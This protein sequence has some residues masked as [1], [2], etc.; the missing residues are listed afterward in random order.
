MPMCPSP[1]SRP[2]LALPLPFIP[3][4]ALATIVSRF[5]MSSLSSG[6]VC[7]SSQKA[8]SHVM[9]FVLDTILHHMGREGQF[10]T[11]THGVRGAIHDMQDVWNSCPVWCAFLQ[12]HVRPQR[13]TQGLEI[14]HMAGRCARRGYATFTIA[15]A[16]LWPAS[17]Q[18]LL[19]SR[20]W[21]QAGAW[22]AA[23]PIEPATTLLPTDMQLALRRH[24]RQPLLLCRSTCGPMRGC[25]GAIGRYGD[26]AFTCPCMFCSPGGRRSWSMPC[27]LPAKHWERTA[28]LSPSNGS[29]T[30]QPQTFERKTAVGLTSSSTEPRRMAAHCVAMPP[31][32][33]N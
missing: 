13:M 29:P 23:I 6:L 24:L 33:L 18:A 8:H 10:P 4:L 2:A 17:S 22:L 12:G 7:K 11:H 1:Y 21:P 9:S 16:C 26:H 27:V 15:T 19:R 30:A 28:R 25:G 14:G 31:S 3:L 20:A 5:S 32:C